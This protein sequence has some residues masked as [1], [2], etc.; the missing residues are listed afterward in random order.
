MSVKASASETPTALEA[1]FEF[2]CYAAPPDECGLPSE[3]GQIRH[4]AEG[5]ATLL[6]YAP[7]RWLVPT[8]GAALR[9]WLADL[10]SHGHGAL[11]DVDGKWQRVRIAEAS[12]ILRSSVNVEATLRHRQCAAATV[13]DCPAILAGDET[14]VD[15]WVV[16]S[17]LESFLSALVGELR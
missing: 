8:P 13:F 12:R 11:I 9:A 7:R 14:T 2:V 1:C 16:S 4:D 5:R 15:L 6:H 10:E 3:P 17:F